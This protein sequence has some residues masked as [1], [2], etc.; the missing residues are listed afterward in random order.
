MFQIKSFSK[1]FVK[2]DKGEKI[3]IKNHGKSFNENFSNK[4]EKK[5][6]KKIRKEILKKF[7]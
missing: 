1:M 7:I 5:L 2:K 6:L 3:Q 4:L